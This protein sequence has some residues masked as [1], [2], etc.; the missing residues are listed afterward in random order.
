MD[1]PNRTTVLMRVEVAQPTF[2]SC[3]M[4]K[5]VRPAQPMSSRPFGSLLT[6]ERLYKIGTC[7]YSLDTTPEGDCGIFLVK[8]VEYIFEKKIKE[9]DKKFERVVAQHNMAFQLYKFAIENP[10]LHFDAKE[11]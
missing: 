5:F 3:G 10:E 4:S 7:D 8:Y 9:M 1:N 11:K 2:K 6:K